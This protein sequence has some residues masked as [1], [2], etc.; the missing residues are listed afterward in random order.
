LGTELFDKQLAGACVGP[1]YPLGGLRPYNSSGGT[2]YLVDPGILQ[3]TR[4]SID[5]ELQITFQELNM[6]HR[7]RLSIALSL[8]LAI[9][10][11]GCSG[12]QIESGVK[13]T[14]TS[15]EKAGGAIE[16]G[17]KGLGEKIKETGAGSKLEGAAATTGS[18]IEKGGEKTHEVLDKTGEKLKEVA[19][20]AGKAVDKAGEKLKD[21]KEKAGEKLK[22]LKDKAGPELKELKD[23]AGEKLKELGDKAKDVIN[24]ETGKN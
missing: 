9:T 17:A 3:Y 1:G 20:A 11:W 19:P 18:V 22:E 6:N 12:E 10:A 15:L 8:P 24:K 21:L 2:N 4:S 23:K 13:T 16:S 5:R 14:G 7:I